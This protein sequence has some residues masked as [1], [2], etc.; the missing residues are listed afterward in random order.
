MTTAFVTL[1]A[2]YKSQG[3]ICDIY[4]KNKQ[5]SHI[6]SKKLVLKKSKIDS[7]EIHYIF[8]LKV[9]TLREMFKQG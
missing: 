7:G 5:M 2:L 1:N 3:F 9:G 8:K 4:F 6:F